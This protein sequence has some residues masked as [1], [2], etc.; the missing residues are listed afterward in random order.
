MPV[1]SSSSNFLLRA[2]DGFSGY[3]ISKMTLPASPDL[4]AAIAA[5]TSDIGKQ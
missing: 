3:A 1:F 4:I 5:S 2:T